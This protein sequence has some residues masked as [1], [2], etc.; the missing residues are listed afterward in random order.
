MASS[1]VRNMRQMIIGGTPVA[2]GIST[3]ATPDGMI[4]GEI[5]IFDNLGDRMDEADATTAGRIRVALMRSATEGPLLSDVIDVS[6]IKSMSRT[7]H[8]A[9]SHQT[10][11]IGYDGATAGTS[12]EV[13]ADNLYYARIYVQELIRSNSDG[14][15]IKHGVFKSTS[16]SA[17][18][19]VSLGLAGSFINNFLREA[20]Q[21]I[22]F[23]AVSNRALATAFNMDEDFTVTKGSIKALCDT[24]IE[25][26]TGTE[27]VVG[28]FIRIADTDATAALTDDVY[29][30]T[31]ISGLELTLD[32]PYQGTSGTRTD[33]NDSTQVIT[34]AQGA[35][36]D[37]GVTMAGQ[38][39]SFD[40]GKFNFAIP[41]WELGLENFGSSNTAS[42]AGSKGKGEAEEIMQMEWFLKGDQ[43]GEIY[44]VGEPSI[45]SGVYEGSLAAAGGGYDTIH[46]VYEQSENVTF[47]PEV[48]PKEL[49]IAVPAT[50]PAYAVTGSTDDITDILEATAVLAG[51]G[52]VDLSMT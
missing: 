16:T 45:H 37:W 33:A 51:L 47:G 10:S 40:P 35:A 19:D 15:R 29:K 52:T 22:R 12:L 48:S 8:V 34:V 36:D 50:A 32:R 39:L 30:I 26:N 49:V 31:A 43:T 1:Q 11:S 4:E 38:D 7:V 25:Y 9:K 46:I 44:H 14:R 42:S 41:S 3:A 2:P 20:E 6:S 24:S 13:I 18:S 23:K 28:D 17:Q 5:G 27:V 21:W